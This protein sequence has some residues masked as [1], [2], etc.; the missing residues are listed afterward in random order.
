MNQ[1]N[2]MNLFCGKFTFNFK[3]GSPAIVVINKARIWGCN[4]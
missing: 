1:Q 3:A 4:L 2:K